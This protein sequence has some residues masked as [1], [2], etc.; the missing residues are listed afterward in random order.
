MQLTLNLFRIHTFTHSFKPFEFE[1]Y[2][3][4]KRSPL[5]TE[6]APSS[7]CA[8]RPDENC[9]VQT[10]IWMENRMRHR[11]EFY[12]FINECSS[13]YGLFFFPTHSLEFKLKLKLLMLLLMLLE[14]RG[15][16]GGTCETLGA[17]TRSMRANMN[18][19]ALSLMQNWRWLGGR[20]PLK[21]GFLSQHSRCAKSAPK[22]RTQTNQAEFT[23]RFLNSA[24]QLLALIQCACTIRHASLILL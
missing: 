4:G 16:W 7:D 10:E 24:L 19:T 1:S 9:E 8:K 5:I 22:C 18:R 21:R 17:T 20:E 2:S 11:N 13:F 12:F 14:T 3:L 23:L 15:N 6:A